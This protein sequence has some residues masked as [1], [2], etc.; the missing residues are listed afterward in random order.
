ML[1]EPTVR[2]PDLDKLLVFI[3]VPSTAQPFFLAGHA[4]VSTGHSKKKSLT[5]I[6]K[7]YAIIT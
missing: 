6:T 5:D 4:L 2:R 1:H 3:C 7:M